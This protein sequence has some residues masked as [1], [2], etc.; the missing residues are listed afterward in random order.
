LMVASW[1]LGFE[2]WCKKL[3]WL[4]TVFLKQIQKLALR[5]KTL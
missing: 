1:A 4:I 3:K 5:N 2:S